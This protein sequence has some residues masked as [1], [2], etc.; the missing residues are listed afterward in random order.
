M[1]ITDDLRWRLGETEYATVDPDYT[2]A[3]RFGTFY[4]H[5][6]FPDR[7]DANQLCRVSC[8]RSEAG[9]MLAELEQY[10]AGLDVGFRKVSGYDPDVWGRLEPTPKSMGWEVWTSSLM[11]LSEESLRGKNASVEIRSVDPASPDLEALY[12]SDGDVDRGFRLA[13]SQFQRLGGEYL[14]GYIDGRPACCTGWYVANGMARFRHVLTAPWARGRG[15]A[16][17]LILHVQRHPT[18]RSQRGLAILVNADGPGGL[19]HDL[20]FRSVAQFW[21]AK[22]DVARA[23]QDQL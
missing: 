18:I 15:C 17:S 13:Q 14:V 5:P 23:P 10:Y 1:S 2:R 22:G 12:R 20:G 11:L 6:D 21:E 16:T 19:Y 7:Y 3:V 8:A 9:L 4:S